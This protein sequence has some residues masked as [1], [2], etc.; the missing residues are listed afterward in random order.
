MRSDAGAVRVRAHVT[1]GIHPQAVFL[2]HGF[3]ARNR[4]L[5]LAAGRGA[6]D[7]DLVT[8][9]GDLAAGSAATGETIVSVARAEG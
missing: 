3:G 7:N 4:R 6:N 8:G 5:S 1:E 2:A 9:R